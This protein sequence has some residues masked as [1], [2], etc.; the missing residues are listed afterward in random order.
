MLFQKGVV[1]NNLDLHL[2][3][4]WHGYIFCYN[5]HYTVYLKYAFIAHFFVIFTGE[6]VG[7]DLPDDQDASLEQ[8]NAT[9]EDET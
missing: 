3:N 1:C 6:A 7:T 5:T 4:S 8:P 2:F 9:Q